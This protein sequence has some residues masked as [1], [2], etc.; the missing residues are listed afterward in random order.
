MDLETVVTTVGTVIATLLAI[1][2]LYINP[3]QAKEL[4][5][6]ELTQA[7]E[8]ERRLA[9]FRAEEDKKRRTFE[10]ELAEKQEKELEQFRATLRSASFEHET[11]FSKLYQE[12]SRTVEEL[13][14]LLLNVEQ[15]YRN[16]L[17][18]DA[19][20]KEEL[21]KEYT[22]A[23]AAVNAFLRQVETKLIY[24]E[25]DRYERVTSQIQQLIRIAW[26]YTSEISKV[27]KSDEDLVTFDELDI[28]QEH[29]KQVSTITLSVLSE[30]R[31]M[32]G[33]NI[34]DNKSK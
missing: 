19:S 22:D 2:G 11:S 9:D 30:F 20:N 28:M 24:F 4:K 15:R 6:F 17:Y 26:N 12:R 1:F 32:L 16:L 7:E 34:P 8:Q 14:P 29:T 18:T 21:Q 25:Q 10:A 31:Q 13:S 23:K 5:N 27:T 3:K 33:I